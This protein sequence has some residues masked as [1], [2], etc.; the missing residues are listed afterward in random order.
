MRRG[1]FYIASLDY[2]LTFPD[3]S[4]L[5]LGALYERT[6]L[7]GPTD[8]RILKGRSLDRTT[9]LQRNDNVNPLDGVRL[10]ADYSRQ[11]G[12]VK[13]ESGYQF[14]Y[15]EHPGDFVYED[16]DPATGTFV[17][18]PEFT[19][20]ILLRRD[21]HSLYGQ[22]SGRY[23]KLEYNGGLRLEYFD[24]RVGLARPDTTYRLERWNLFPSANLK[25][26]LR[27]GL[28]LKAGYSRRIERTTTFKMTPFP[29]REHNETL[30]QG[31][32]ELLPELSDVVELGLSGNWGD[33]S[34]FANVYY[35]HVSD[36]INRVNTIYNDTILNRIYTNAGN[37]RAYGIEAGATLFPLP[38]WRLYL[39]GNVYDYRIEGRLFDEPVST[40][41]TV[42][43]ISA[44]TGVTFTKTFGGQIG[45][46][47]LSERVTAQGTDSR[48]F[49]P[50][51]S[52]RKEFPKQRLSFTF[53]WQN[54]DLG[55]WKANEQSITT[56]QADFFT[57]TNYVYEVDILR[58]AVSYQFTRVRREEERVESEFGG[59]EF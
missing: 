59:R 22:A 33:H 44:S 39:S 32:A 28:A 46:D 35:R 24:R 36:V 6:E 53:Q 9:E 45:I 48:F 3:E 19:N 4:S 18:N 57:T 54:I 12:A 58:L 7:G 21:I 56:R 55:L 38:G 14:R 23:G 34:A 1:D 49:N 52:L 17:V 31:D 5:S 15:L 20:R 8:N 37:A 41:S 11:I 50:Y 27:D 30:E 2:A 10:Q 47:Y 42:Y 26:R 16:L 43:S 29:E 13:V 40:G 51:L 25:L